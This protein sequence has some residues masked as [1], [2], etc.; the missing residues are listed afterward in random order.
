[1]QFH[2]GESGASWWLTMMRTKLVKHRAWVN[3][4]SR[5]FALRM[6]WTVLLINVGIRS[7]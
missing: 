6:I 3:R 4:H 5:K 7:P 1:M 2:V